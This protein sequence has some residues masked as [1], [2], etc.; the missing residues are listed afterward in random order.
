MTSAQGGGAP[1]PSGGGGNYSDYW[2]GVL[3]SNV[4]TQFGGG[5]IPPALPGQQAA[6]PGQKQLFG[7]PG[8]PAPLGGGT[9]SANAVEHDLLAKLA[10]ATANHYAAS[11]VPAT[12]AAPGSPW[13]SMNPASMAANEFGPQYALLDR[14]AQE[15]QGKY[16]AAGN[17]VGSMWD[18]LSKQTAGNENHIK[19][20]YA[21]SGAATG[22]AFN[23]AI[24][25]TNGAFSD[26]RSQIAD[27][28]QRLGV[29]AAV[30][31]ALSD[32]SNQQ[33]RLDAL[34]GNSGANW[35]GLN[36]TLGNNEV[37]FNRN[38]A[39]ID[40]QSGINA[41]GNFQSQLM[42]AL[43]AL[44]DKR[45]TLQGQQGAAQN[46]YGLD[47]AKNQQT[48]QTANADRASLD[49]YHQAQMML[50]A[51][52]LKQAADQFQQ[53]NGSAANKNLSATEYLAQQAANE[54][55]G[56]GVSAEN[57]KNAILDTV[58][59]GDPNNPGA[60]MHWKN[61]GDFVQSVLARNPNSQHNGGD[62]RQLEQLALDYYTR[63]AGGANKAI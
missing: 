30:P 24:A 27:I 2:N 53:T 45:L 55:G 28:A 23:D 14:M 11:G 39:N 42:A 1:V 12:P 20:N 52:K 7:A 46:T 58:S 8:A 48:A 13:D 36:N 60:A 18:A 16:T 22:K 51:A 17:Q 29:S 62:Y 50:D 15:A 5:G 19:Q 63:L 38:N 4:P 56:A 10:A 6:A 33:A 37:S 9:N 43:N 26:S 54:Y 41:R 44:G 49:Q 32:G 31:S 47:I 35:Q 40:T 25:A 21:Q 57:A 3:K 59:Q 61:A 34:I